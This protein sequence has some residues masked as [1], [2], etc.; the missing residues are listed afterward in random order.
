MIEQYKQIG[1]CFSSVYEAADFAGVEL[2]RFNH[3]NCRADVAGDPHG[4]GDVSIR[5]TPDGRGGR[6]YL[7]KTG[8]RVSFHEDAGRKLTKQERKRVAR[9]NEIKR[10]ESTA[11]EKIKEAFAIE[12]C[13]QI[14]RSCSLTSFHPY[15]EK[16]RLRCERPFHVIHANEI[17]AI[18]RE[19]GVRG[20]RPGYK[21]GETFKRFK[22]ELIVIPCHINGEIKTLEFIDAQGRK[23]F[24]KDTSK[25]GSYWMT[26]FY[27]SFEASPI[28]AIAEGVATA[29]SIDLVEGIPCVAAMDAGN[30]V[31]VA[32]HWASQFPTKKFLIMA[33]N[34]QKG[35]EYG[36][37]ARAAIGGELHIAPVND[38]ITASFQAMT[39][40]DKAPSDF[41]DVYIARGML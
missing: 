38:E 10:A 17:D 9:E 26:R 40:S 7:H 1:K 32:K 27:D 41:N 20:Y 31:S 11:A 24:M 29:L 28:I 13:Y 22:G 6:I 23:R 37:A 18:L 39:G 15:L 36:K 2:K 35:I 3:T 8:E 19:R 14:Y 25:S 34:D 30:L 33:D 5:M 4:K 12:L 16:K 21:D